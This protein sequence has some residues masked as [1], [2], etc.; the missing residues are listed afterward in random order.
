MWEQ[1][2]CFGEVEGR[3]K[4]RILR[5]VVRMKE[6]ETYGTKGN[7]IKYWKIL[8]KK[9]KNKEES[10]TTRV[11]RKIRFPRSCS[12]EERCY[13]GSGDTGV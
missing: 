12:R 8:K 4:M 6:R 2:S 9:D 1:I 11:I 10:E 7:K 13:E 5:R 3:D